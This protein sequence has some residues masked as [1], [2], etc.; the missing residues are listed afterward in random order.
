MQNGQQQKRTRKLLIDHSLGRILNIICVDELGSYIYELAATYITMLS[1]YF[2]FC[3]VIAAFYSCNS[4]NQ[5]VK[6]VQ[7]G[8]Q[9][10]SHSSNTDIAD[11]DFSTF[12]EQF[13]KDTAFQ[14]N[15]TKFP[16]RIKQYDIENDKDT[17]IYEQQSAF[18][19]MDFRKRKSE[20]RYDQWKQEIVLDKSQ[21]KATIEIRGIE[22]GIVVDYHF[23]MRDGKWM[24]VGIDDS[25]T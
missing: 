23:E 9:V 6:A 15:R 21:R 18:E 7:S 2:V 10:S 12:I 16:L 3:L 17:I 13:S 1:H 19:M 4:G 5:R 14:I 22:N 8:Q 25:S 24:L 20:G 11:K